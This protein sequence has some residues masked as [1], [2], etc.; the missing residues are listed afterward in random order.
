MSEIKICVICD[1]EY[2][3][4]GNNAR[5]VEDGQCCNECN[6]KKVIPARLGRL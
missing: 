2:E 4:W 5:P 1:E 6:F 3:G